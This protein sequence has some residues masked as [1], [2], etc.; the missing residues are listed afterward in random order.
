MYLAQYVR[1][2]R[3]QY[4]LRGIRSVKDYEF[5]RAMRHVN[6]DIN[7]AVTTVF[8]MPPREISEVSSSLV[9]GLVGPTGWEDIVSQYV[10]SQVMEMLFKR[11]WDGGGEE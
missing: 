8:L 2:E 6:F 4:I 3:A 1:D 5:E 9:K 11:R 10:P 7:A